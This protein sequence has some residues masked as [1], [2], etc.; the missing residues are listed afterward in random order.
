MNF[1]AGFTPEAQAAF[2]FAADIWNSLLVTTV[3]IVI[4]ATFNSAGN[5]FNLGS[6]GPETFFLIGGSAIPVGLV[7]QLVGFDANGADPEINA[8]FNS[9]RTDWYF[10]TDGNVPSGKVDF[11]SVVLHE[12]GHGLGFVSS[13][14]FSSGTGSFSNPPIKFDTF[15]ENGAN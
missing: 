15:I 11:V 1:A 14:A 3:P 6:A 9:D 7:N 12:I 4:N 2:Q 10:G 13:D 8:N 5:P